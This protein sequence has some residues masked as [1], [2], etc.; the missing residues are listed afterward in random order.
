MNKSIFNLRKKLVLN[1]IFKI[2]LITAK[3]IFKFI[4]KLKEFLL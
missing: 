2:L 4:Y 3:T 1:Y